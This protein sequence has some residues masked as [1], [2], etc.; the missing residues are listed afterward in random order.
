MLVIEDGSIVSGSD[1]YV[2][3][4]D[5]IAY[6]A[7]LGVTVP[8]TA[9]TDVQLVKAAQYIGSFEGRLKGTRVTRDQY[10]AYPRKDLFI[11]GFAWDE[12]EIP[13]NVVLCQMQVALDI[14]EGIDPYNP[15]T[16]GSTAI[17]SER[18][19]GAVTVQYAVKDA[20]K[21]SRNSSSSAL[22]S[23]LLEYSGLRIVLERA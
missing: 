4:A 18:V 10:M 5:Y 21:L 3:R 16:S 7:S 14:N 2:S 1:S 12:D 19:E 15:P 23:S 6:A 20:A 11:D 17:K 22:L 9:A 13:R 8:D